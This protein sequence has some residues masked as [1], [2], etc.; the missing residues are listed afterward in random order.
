MY[1]NLL[2]Q[3]LMNPHL[4]SIPSLRSLTT[5]RLSGGDLQGLGWEADRAFDSEVLG[6][7]ALDELLADFLEGGN[8][9]AGQGDADFVGF[10]DRNNISKFMRWEIEMDGGE[11][12]QGPRRNLSLCCRTS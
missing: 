4:E 6:L 7:G 11:D 12:V 1:K 3:T 2:N 9:S 8:L 10:L 5:G